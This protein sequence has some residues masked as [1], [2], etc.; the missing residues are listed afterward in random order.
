MSKLFKKESIKKG[1]GDVTKTANIHV[2]QITPIQLKTPTPTF[3]R[4][5]DTRA[6]YKYMAT[7]LYTY[8]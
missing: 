6:I 4:K 5:T 2:D 3:S 7:P 8:F 1:I